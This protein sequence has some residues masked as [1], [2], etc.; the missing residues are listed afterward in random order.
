M[1]EEVTLLKGRLTGV[2]S[3][4][5]A[6]LEIFKGELYGKTVLLCQCGMGKV[7]AGAATQLLVTKY[8]IEAIVFSG[9]AGNMTSKIG[10]GDVCLGKEVLYHDAEIRMINQHYPHMDSYMGD[11]NL[12]AAAS[13]ACE[14]TGTKYIAG[15]I[16]TGD[17]FIGDSE[18]KNRI[19]AACNP[20]CVEMEGAAIAHIACKNDI[21]FLIIRS[22]SD[23]ADED[24]TETLVV[25][26]FDISEYCDKAAKICEL[27]VK[28]C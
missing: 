10:I 17:L 8:G 26:Q 18:T 19:R 23:N 3:E 14:E 20:D 2:T 25:K 7:A 4:K 5:V 12:I 11:E 1:P 22:M 9:I 27:T 6:G 28:Y 15:K 16:A 13:R 24:A 21:P